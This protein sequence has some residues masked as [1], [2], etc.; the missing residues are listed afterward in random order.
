MELVRPQQRDACPWSGRRGSRPSAEG[1]PG[2][3]RIAS[4]A[5]RAGAGAAARTRR[6]DEVQEI[7]LLGCHRAQGVQWEV[8]GVK[9]AIWVQLQHVV[10][11]DGVARGEGERSISLRSD[12][13]SKWELSVSWGAVF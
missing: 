3:A 1:R 4:L 6:E 9:V 13:R 5:A 2:A 12:Y 8:D 10:V 11:W 7:Q